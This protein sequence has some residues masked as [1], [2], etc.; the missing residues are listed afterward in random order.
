MANIGLPTVVDGKSKGNELVTG[1]H[2][3]G[4]GL[5]GIGSSVDGSR[6][7]QGRW[8]DAV[9]LGSRTEAVPLLDG[10]TVRREHPPPVLGFR[11]TG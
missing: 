1:V 8:R 7:L 5:T 6:H 10:G 9:T 2:V 11:R 4:T 3:G